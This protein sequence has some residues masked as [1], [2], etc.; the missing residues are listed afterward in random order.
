MFAPLLILI[1][2]MGFMPQPFLDRMAPSLERTLV[3]AQ[4]R[5]AM[6]VTLSAAG[7]ARRAAGRRRCAMMPFAMPAFLPVDWWA[8]GA[9][10]ALTLGTLVLLMLEFLPAKEGSARGAVVALLSLVAAGGSVYRVHDA[11]RALFGGML[12]HDGFTVFFTLLLCAIGALTVLLSWDYVRR[13]R[14]DQAEYYALL[15]CATVG[16]MIMAACER[17]DHGVPRPRADVDRALR[18]G[19]LPPQPARV[20]RGGDEV[21]PARR[22]R[23]R[24]PALRHR[25]ALR[26]HRHH[27]AAGDGELPAHLADARQ[28]RCS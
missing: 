16:M 14:I 20:E 2:W 15:L 12:V 21:L 8:M 11:R 27:P 4:E 1:F 25:A 10:I 7:A 9:M 17:P 24:V 13:T 19:R 3:L 6:S 26:R 22:V 28:P 5:A 23:Q 18:A